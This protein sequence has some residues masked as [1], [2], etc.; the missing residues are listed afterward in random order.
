MLI[1][2]YAGFDEFKYRPV[3]GAGTSEAQESGGAQSILA[4]VTLSLLPNCL[5]MATVAVSGKT[6]RRS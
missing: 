2:Q 5:G 6:R 3:D 1:V 4:A